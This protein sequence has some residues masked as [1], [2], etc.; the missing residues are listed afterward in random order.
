M[1]LFSKNQKKI[2][3]TEIIFEFMKFPSDARERKRVEM[4]VSIENV[5]NL[6]T[7][8]I[9][10]SIAQLRP[11]CVVAASVTGLKH[12]FNNSNFLWAIPWRWT[13]ACCPMCALHHVSTVS[14]TTNALCKRCRG[15]DTIVITLFI[16]CSLC[17]CVY[18]VIE[19]GC[20]RS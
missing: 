6:S 1:E 2:L 5:W 15:R 3:G 19:I 20:C 16:V 18:Y 9:I 14:L 17:V 8:Y 13:I 7:F 10:W 12:T 4:P 11:K